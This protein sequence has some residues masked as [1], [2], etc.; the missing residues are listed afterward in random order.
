MQCLHMRIKADRTLNLEHIAKTESIVS[1]C[2]EL[3]NGP[4]E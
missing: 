1:I 4:D 2:A 3:G